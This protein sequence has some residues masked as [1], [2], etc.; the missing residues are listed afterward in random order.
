MEASMIVSVKFFR[1]YLKTLLDISPVVNS[2][3]EYSFKLECKT[4]VCKSI[5]MPVEHNGF[6]EFSLSARKIISTIKILKHVS[7]Q[8]IKVVITDTNF[9]LF[10]SFSI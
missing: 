6:T 2:D 3:D 4:L 10:I 5:E 9:P 1:N 7:D 8:P